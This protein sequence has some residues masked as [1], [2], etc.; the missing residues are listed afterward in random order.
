MN[1]IDRETLRIAVMRIL[2]N[3]T[4]YPEKVQPHILGQNMAPLCDKVVDS[5]LFTT[6]KEP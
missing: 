6:I 5:I 4:N 1:E 2:R 3:A